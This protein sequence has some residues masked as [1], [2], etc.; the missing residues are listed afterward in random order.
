MVCICL[1][2]ISLLNAH[3]DPGMREAHS[4]T[5][6]GKKR[7]RFDDLT[8]LLNN[9]AKGKLWVPIIEQ[10]FSEQYLENIYC[11][12]KKLT[13]NLHLSQLAAKFQMESKI[14]KT[15]TTEY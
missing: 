2:T 12:K 8:L 10:C 11:Y 13:L 6:W 15:K 4:S 3:F 14:E 5:E 7:K 1:V 9:M